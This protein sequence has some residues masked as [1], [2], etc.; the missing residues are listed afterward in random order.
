MPADGIWQLQTLAEWPQK[1]VPNHLQWFTTNSCRAV[2]AALKCCKEKLHLHIS[3]YFGLRL[4]SKARIGLQ[5]LEH[6]SKDRD[7][8][9]FCGTVFRCLCNIAAI[10]LAN[11]SHYQDVSGVTWS[12]VK[13][14]QCCEDQGTIS[15][16]PKQLDG[17]KCLCPSARYPAA[18]ASVT[19]LSKTRILQ[20]AKPTWP[21]CFASQDIDDIVPNCKSF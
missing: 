19:A 18:V 7:L 3:D 4:I 5:A 1:R 10:A 11:R 16:S 2:V 8:V 6:H 12:A 15:L 14:L 13:P 9:A 20:I 21:M 17:N